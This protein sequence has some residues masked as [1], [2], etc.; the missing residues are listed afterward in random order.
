LVLAKKCVEKDS[1]YGISCFM[2]WIVV[3]LDKRV[4]DELAALP[5]DIQARY[6]RIS[7]IISTY[8]IDRVRE[9][10][11]K[12]LEGKLW[13]MRMKGKDGIARA[14][15]VTAQEKRVVVLRVFVKKTQKTPHR[16]LE[17]A[18]QRMKEVL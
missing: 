8:G 17:I 16:E 12:H 15:Y 10:Y 4:D 13:E 14:I 2:T 3:A 7:E 1:L 6:S 11:V 18:R 9:P 5:V